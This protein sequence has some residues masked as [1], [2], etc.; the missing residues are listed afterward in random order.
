MAIR[1]KA[2]HYRDGQSEKPEPGWIREWIR[3]WLRRCEDQRRWKELTKTAR[4][5]RIRLEVYRGEFWKD[6]NGP[7][8]AG[9]DLYWRREYAE[10]DRVFE[11]LLR[12]LEKFEVN[13]F[14][15]KENLHFPLDSFPREVRESAR[16]WQAEIVREACCYW[17]IWRSANPD[18]TPDLRQ[19]VLTDLKLNGVNFCR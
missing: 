10:A 12:V 9:R 1:T 7:S 15:M 8:T 16:W 19:Q 2:T 18:A 4:Q 6:W 17:N 5:N 11:G 14:G 13:Q 3:N